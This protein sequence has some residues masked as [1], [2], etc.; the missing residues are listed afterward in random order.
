MFSS[1]SKPVNIVPDIDDV[2]EAHHHANLLN[3]SIKQVNCIGGMAGIE[4][5]PSNSNDWT[6]LSPCKLGQGSSRYR[7]TTSEL[8]VRYRRFRVMRPV[9]SSYTD[10]GCLYSMSKIGKVPDGT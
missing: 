9:V 8:Q 5:T 7:S 3:S 4:P 6:Q 1:I 2:I 10:I